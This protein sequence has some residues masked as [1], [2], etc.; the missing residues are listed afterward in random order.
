MK[1]PF[2]I[3]GERAFFFS[4]YNIYGI[5]GGL[6]GLKK[7]ISWRLTCAWTLAFESALNFKDGRPEIDMAMPIP[8]SYEGAK[9]HARRR[10]VDDQGL[11]RNP[12]YK[13]ILLF[14]KRDPLLRVYLTR[15]QQTTIC[16]FGLRAELTESPRLDQMS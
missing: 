14:H 7:S 4:A 15:G 6:Q 1:S 8:R 9:P 12:M 16:Y 13:K 10:A 11:I 5:E 2:C 3:I